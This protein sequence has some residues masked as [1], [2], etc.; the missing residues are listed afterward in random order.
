MFISSEMVEGTWKM[1]TE[2]DRV[3]QLPDRTLPNNFWV[4]LPWWKLKRYLRFPRLLSSRIVVLIPH[5][6]AGN[7][8]LPLNI[9]LMHGWC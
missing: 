4:V 5:I 2:V 3:N 1:H 7:T 9:F 8:T 6:E